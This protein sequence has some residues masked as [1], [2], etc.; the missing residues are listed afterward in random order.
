VLVNEELPR[1]L[2]DQLVRVG[3]FVVLFSAGIIQLFFIRALDRN[4][5]HYLMRL[6]ERHPILLRMFGPPGRDAELKGYAVAKRIGG[7]I[8]IIISFIFL[9]S[10]FKPLD[11]CDDHYWSITRRDPC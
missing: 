9:V 4:L 3:L 1:S 8:L 10:A 11:P 5:R 7:V 2:A 6:Y